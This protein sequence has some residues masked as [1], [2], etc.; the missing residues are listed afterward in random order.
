MSRMLEALKQ[1]EAKSPPRRSAIEP[2]SPEEL[3]SFGLGRSAKLP[4]SAPAQAPPPDQPAPSD[5]AAPRP[6]RP[7]QIDEPPA[8]PIAPQPTQEPSPGFEFEPGRPLARP[9]SPLEEEQKQPFRELAQKVLAQ[10]S[11][12]PAGAILFTSPGDGEG[13]TSTL[14]SLAVVLAETAEVEIAA[15]DA[16]LQ[17]PALGN[18]LGIWAG[19]GLVD[20]L[21]GEA[22]WR[23]LVR[24]TSVPRLSVLPA[25][26]LPADHDCLP[27][28]SKLALVLDALRACYHLVL[29]DAPSLAYPEVAPWSRLCDGTYLVAQLGQTGR[30]AA[31]RAVRLI[32]RHGGRVLGC[33]LV[34]AVPAG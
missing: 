14:A 17:N 5:E 32:D 7:A 3:R 28:E 27:T 25:G 16:N 31:R 4:A 20:V 26:P 15:V 33:V 29:I 9:L 11:P 22:D 8:R 12:G 34:D 19:R 18:R 21:A 30:R 24:R 23:E 6:L 1:I 13:T 2:I 10:R